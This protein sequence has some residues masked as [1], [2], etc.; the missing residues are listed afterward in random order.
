MKKIYMTP[1]TDSVE[2]RLQTMIAGSLTLNEEDGTGT[3]FDE[4]AIGDALSR[5][6]DNE[7]SYDEEDGWAF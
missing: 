5:E 6:M 7:W 1:S 3:F 2:V 4:V